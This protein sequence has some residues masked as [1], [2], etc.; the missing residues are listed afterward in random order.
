MSVMPPQDQFVQLWAAFYSQ[1][2]IVLDNQS[3]KANNVNDNDKARKEQVQKIL[4]T[5]TKL[6]F[7]MD[8]SKKTVA[9]EHAGGA[10]ELIV[11]LVNE[12]PLDDMILLQGLKAVKCCVIRNKAGRARCRSAG[13]VN[14]LS[15]TLESYTVKDSPKSGK[16]DT[17]VE[18]SL[19]TLAAICLG[20]DINALQVNY[21]LFSRER[22]L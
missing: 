19:T 1:A 5:T 9:V 21:E 15:H 18:E 22:I 16:S 17:I 3:K 2:V 13:V 14:L 7:G 11:S 10:L 12:Y 8:A 4:A 6:I 20:D